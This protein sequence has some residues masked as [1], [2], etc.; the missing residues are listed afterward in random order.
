MNF[1]LTAKE[2]LAIV[3]AHWEMFGAAQTLREVI[4]HL[5]APDTRDDGFDRE[6]GVDTTRHVMPDEAGLPAG[7]LDSA[8]S[9]VPTPARVI[10]H[11]LQSLPIQHRDFT[12]VDFGSG[13]GRALLVASEFEFS[14]IIGVEASAMLHEVALRNVA[15]YTSST[16]RSQDIQCFNM[17]CLDFELPRSNAVLYMYHP[18]GASVLRRVLAR[19]RQS[20]DESPR[21]FFII[22]VCPTYGRV[23]SEVPG[24]QKLRDFQVIRFDHSWGMYR[25][26]PPGTGQSRR[27]A[28]P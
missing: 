9:Y 15:R 5:V 2:K 23:F 28:A 12:F 13:K 27:P 8:S 18:F 17:D 20:V 26:V 14:R 7:V 24:F 6:H 25:C 22:Y 4:A 19:V 3:K 1:H 21:E 16:R 11:A 10:R